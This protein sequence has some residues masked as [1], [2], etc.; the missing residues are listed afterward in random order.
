MTSSG[1][2]SPADGLRAISTGSPTLPLL[3]V[4][5]GSLV[6]QGILQGFTTR[7]GGRR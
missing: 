7:G 2:L 6:A 1:D 3:L 5:L 4:S